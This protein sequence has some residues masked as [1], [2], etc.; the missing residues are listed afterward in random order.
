M[1]KARLKPEM[2]KNCEATVLERPD[3]TSTWNGGLKNRYVNCMTIGRAFKVYINGFWWITDKMDWET[4]EECEVNIYR[5]LA[6]YERI[7][8]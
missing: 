8:R 4:T 6:R 3:F 5:S 7:K 1:V 2:F